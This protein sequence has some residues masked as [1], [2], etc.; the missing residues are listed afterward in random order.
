MDKV[1]KRW[2]R[3]VLPGLQC[4]ENREILPSWGMSTRKYSNVVSDRQDTHLGT[5]AQY[6]LRLGNYS[7]I[8]TSPSAN[9]C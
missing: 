4:F 3:S 2:V 7:T 1:Q 6:R 9:T 8:L 5:S